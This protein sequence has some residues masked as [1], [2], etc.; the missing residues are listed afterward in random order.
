[1]GCWLYRVVK[2]PRFLC[3]FIHSYFPYKRVEMKSLVISECLWNFHIFNIWIVLKKEKAD[4]FWNNFTIFVV[5]RATRADFP[6]LLRCFL[7]TLHLDRHV[8]SQNNLWP[9]LLL[10]QMEWQ[11]FAERVWSSP[12]MSSSASQR[13]TGLDGGGSWWFW[14]YWSLKKKRLCL[15]RNS[16]C[17]AKANWLSLKW[18]QLSLSGSRMLIKCTKH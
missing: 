16:V 3:A 17:M 11:I 9:H 2:P 5:S 15:E 1:M 7:P 12:W 10:W 4:W 13:S 14:K 8:G 6:L 18:P